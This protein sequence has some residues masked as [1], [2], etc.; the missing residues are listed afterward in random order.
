MTP[1]PELETK[2]LLLR[3]IK[4]SDSQDIFQI[5]SSDEVTRFYDVE[6]F[7]NTK[8]A[9]ELIQRWKERFENGQVIR[10]G[11][12]LK[13]DNRIIGTC[14]F[15]GWMKQHYKAVMG[16]EL[17]PEFWRQ[18]YITEVTRK[19]VEYGFKN[20]ELN[21]IEAFVEPENAGSRKLLEKIGFSEE[22]IL[23]EHFIW[24]NRFVDNV[25]YAFLKKEYV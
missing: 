23:K 8:Q 20:L 7:T 13:S 5:F 1:F 25:I 16:Y 3:E 6:T 9:E 22:G 14:G 15:H 4:Q 24:K 21:R 12:A 18:G 19:I 2:R 10:W 17:T 11:I